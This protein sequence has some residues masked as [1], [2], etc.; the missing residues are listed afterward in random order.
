VAAPPAP[1]PAPAPTAPRTLSVKLDTVPTG[2]AVL[3]RGQPVGKTPYALELNEDQPPTSV[4][5]QA[6]GHDDLKVTL[7]PRDVLAGGTTSFRYELQ[8]TA[9]APAPAAPAPGPK[10]VKTAPQPA[11]EARP[12]PK[13]APAPAPKPAPAPAVKL[14]PKLNW[15]EE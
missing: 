14:K 15:D 6:P 9:V 2:A 13:P 7:N 4:V 3:A 11:G 5:F 1:A 12:A 8:K 10:V